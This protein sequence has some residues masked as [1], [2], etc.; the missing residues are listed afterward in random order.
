MELD[1]PLPSGKILDNQRMDVAGRSL[2]PI[3]HHFQER[4]QSV[5]V[6]I[7]CLIRMDKENIDKLVAQDI[8]SWVDELRPEYTTDAISENR[9]TIKGFED[10]VK[11]L[12]RLRT[13]SEQGIQVRYVCQILDTWRLPSHSHYSSD[14][15][16]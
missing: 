4:K 3:M 6:A 1:D 5:Q 7:D 13:K 8:S 12:E 10:R 14:G 15:S 2:A 9:K 11:I 16:I